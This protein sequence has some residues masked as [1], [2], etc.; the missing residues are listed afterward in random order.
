M[1]IKKHAFLLLL[2]LT[3]FFGCDSLSQEEKVEDY[4][5]FIEQIAPSNLETLNERYHQGN[6]GL[7]CSTLNEYGFTGFSR[8]LFPNGV[9]PC[10][11]RKELKQELPYSNNLL[12]QTKWQLVENSAYTGVTNIS[13]LVTKE[14]ISLDGCTICEGKDINNVPLQ[15]KFTFQP[16]YKNNIEVVGSEIVVYVDAQGVNRIWGNW[17]PAVDPGFIEFG[18]ISAV[19]KMIGKRLSYADEDNQVFELVIL[20]EHIAGNPELRFVTID[21]NEGM[22]IHKVWVINILKEDENELRWQSY[23]STI[24]G[25]ILDVRLL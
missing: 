20:K 14:I 6:N 24:T 2:A 11:E 25:E 23:I 21:V 16:Q 13:E 12:L 10:L 1:I 5:V 22:E 7:I 3:L 15:W 8:V 17:Y 19:E 18:S 4:P 9:N